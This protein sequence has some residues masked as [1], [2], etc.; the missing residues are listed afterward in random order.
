MKYVGGKGSAQEVE[1]IGAMEV[2]VGRAEVAFT[3]VGQPLSR[4]LAPV[5]PSAE[6]DRMRPHS[7]A[8]HRFLE[9]EPAQNSRRVGAYLNASPNLAQ[10]R[11]LLKYLNV[12]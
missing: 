10:V 2:I 5:V 12:K 7:E 4:E 9:S 6:D 3:R 1:Q 11:S 8:A